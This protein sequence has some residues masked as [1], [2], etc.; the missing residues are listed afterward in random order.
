MEILFTDPKL[1]S[2]RQ[3]AVAGNWARLFQIAPRGCVGSAGPTMA[4]GSRGACGDDANIPLG[5]PAGEAAYYYWNRTN[6]ARKNLTINDLRVR[7]NASGQI[8]NVPLT[9][10]E[11]RD[12]FDNYQWARHDWKCTP[13]QL[14]KYTYDAMGGRK[15][16]PLAQCAESSAS[17]RRKAVKKVAAVAVLVTGAIFLGP[18]ILAAA[19]KGAAAVGAGV[20]KV[21][22]AAGGLV[23]SI[24]N[25]R[26]VK[27]IAEGKAPPPPIDVNDA[28]FGDWA[29]EVGVQEWQES[30]QRKMTRAEER[31]LRAEIAAMQSQLA[32]EVP[33]FTPQP[34]PYLPPAVTQIQ[35]REVQQASAG[36]TQIDKFILPAALVAGA[37]ILGG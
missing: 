1:N 33:R 16:Y 30:Q 5:S 23:K 35:A 22:A 7:K 17:R 6:P 11:I 31:A 24:N 13:G 26:T 8:E 3:A 27:A 2:M 10:V 28:S 12:Y 9:E 14:E 19:G 37:L 25:A 34:S 29:F 21:G 36:G 20:S 4:D 15:I 32:N 18:A